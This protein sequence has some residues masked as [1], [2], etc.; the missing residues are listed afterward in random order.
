MRERRLPVRPSLEH[1][2]HE[3]RELLRAAPGPASTLAEAELEL[4]RSYGAADWDR[5]VLACRLVDAIWSDDVDTVR[6]L[7]LEHPRL[8]HEDALVRKGNWG[9]PM[10]YA[11]NLG[12]DRI[13]LMLHALGATDLRSALDRAALQGRIDTAR[14][15]HSM[16][17]SPTPP[18]GALGGPAYTLSAPGTALLLELGAPVLDEHGRGIA[19]VGV[20]LESDSRKPSDKHAILEMYMQH[21]VPLPDTPMMALHRGRIDL[22]DA[23]LRRDPHLLRRTFRFGEIFPPA[24]GCHDEE[25]PRTPLDGATLLHVCVEFDELE[26]AHWLLD[27]GMNVDAPAAADADGFGGHTALFGAVVCYANFWDNFRGVAG[28]GHF[29]RLL[30]DHGADPN[31]RASLRT[32][33]Q[34]AG[35][36]TTSEARDVTPIGWGRAF[37]YRMVV[38]EPAMHLVAE[39]GGR[40]EP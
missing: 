26:I 39:R 18:G 9:P 24:L 16:A 34:V 25:Y 17:G 31:A 1:L 7:L 2:Q 30:L 5:L 27:R 20:V 19:P 29:A 14:M 36:W 4:A 28:D 35:A 12:R 33:F 13:I 37:G 21:G 40:G 15:L 10:S 32:R 6:A 8:L 38:S 22:L 11:A 3:A 23:H